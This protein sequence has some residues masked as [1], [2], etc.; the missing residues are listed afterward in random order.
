M[1]R[2]LLLWLTTPCPPYV[3][4]MRYLYQLIAMH[5]R[6][7]RNRSS[8]QQHLSRTRDFIL[9]STERCRSHERVVVLG[10]G[11]LLDIPLKELSAR[12]RTVVLVDIV[13]L[14]EILKQ[15][16]GY[17]NVRLVQ[18]DIMGAAEA[19]YDSIRRGKGV[20]PHAIPFFPE[21]DEETG[22]LISLNVLSQLSAVPYDYVM[23]KMPNCD[24]DALVA[25]GN[26]VRSA[27]LQALE[28]S[29]ADVCLITDYS[30]SWRS[31]AGEL[32]EEGSTVGNIALPVPAAFWTWHI[33][34]IGEISKKWSKDLTVGAWFMSK[35]NPQ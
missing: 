19:L 23:R 6:Y 14:P 34:P 15:I 2:E 28:Q 18:C 7:R 26:T 1:L 16:T 10:S 9:S 21:V 27:H 24:E 29:P 3:R 20:L 8:W 35:S 11:L 25:W 33:A 13:H 30:Y 17:P 4:R 32:L 31:V 12:F 5:G 22:L